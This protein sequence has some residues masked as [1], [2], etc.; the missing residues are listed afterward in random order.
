[1]RTWAPRGKGKGKNHTFKQKPHIK[2]YSILKSVTLKKRIQKNRTKN[3]KGIG[4]KRP[5]TERNVAR[6][7]PEK[8]FE[9]S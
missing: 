9:Y 6:H 1:M 7:S 5:D 4:V 8:P 3:Q 2:D